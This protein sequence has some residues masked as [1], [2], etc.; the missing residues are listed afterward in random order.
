MSLIG[1]RKII[2]NNSWSCPSTNAG[3]VQI[4]RDFLAV[5]EKE[6]GWKGIVKEIDVDNVKKLTVVAGSVM[7]L[8]DLFSLK[9]G[10]HSRKLDYEQ[11][12]H[13]ILHIGL[14]MMILEKSNRG[15]FFFNLD[16]IIV[17]DHVFF[18]VGKLDHVLSR[19][20]QEQLLL[21][22]PMKFTK[23]DQQFLA[24]ELQNGLIDTLPFYTSITVGYYSLAK[25]CIYCLDLHDSIANLDQIKDSKMY[26]FLLRCLQ[27]D[28]QERFFLY[29]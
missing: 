20:K 16:D 23:T 6:P 24:P 9:E 27:V 21:S 2:N 7:T 3:E 25:L 18:L 12:E 11:V 10:Q 5:L 4:Y 13:M 26:F 8:S 17:I 22:Y 29:L 1:G 19:Y 14:Q 15:V 28:P